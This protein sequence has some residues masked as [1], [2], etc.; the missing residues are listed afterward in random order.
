MED[1]LRRLA[2]HFDL[3]FGLPSNSRGKEIGKT[4][5]KTTI[6]ANVFFSRHANF[7]AT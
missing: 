2:N 5:S 1:P 7:A 3:R 4:F 6:R